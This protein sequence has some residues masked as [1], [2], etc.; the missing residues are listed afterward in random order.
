MVG[1]ASLPEIFFFVEDLIM[2]HSIFTAN[3]AFQSSTQKKTAI[4]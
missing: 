1:I 4:N 3:H 2:R